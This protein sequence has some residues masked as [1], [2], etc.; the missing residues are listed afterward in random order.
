MY[1]VLTDTL[2]I[3]LFRIVI[4]LALSGMTGKSKYA[5]GTV[6][7]D[8]RTEDP[9]GRNSCN[10]QYCSPKRA[11]IES[12]IQMASLLYARRTQR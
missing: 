5:L 1:F 6:C 3:P 8:R 12:N 4:Q 2:D 7:T 11:P 10:M 9:H